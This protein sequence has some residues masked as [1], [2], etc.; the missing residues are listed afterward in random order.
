MVHV[1][2]KAVMYPKNN[3]NLNESLLLGFILSILVLTK[4]KEDDEGRVISRDLYD[5]SVTMLVFQIFITLLFF[6]QNWDNIYTYI[7]I[8]LTYSILNIA[9]PILIIY[10]GVGSRITL[11]DNA[12]AITVI[13]ITIYYLFFN[14][15]VFRTTM[16]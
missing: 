13:V 5:L 8:F 9:L 16:T 4:Y 12:I 11:N 14:K 15:L 1:D 10:K 3:D 7:L 2:F 6:L